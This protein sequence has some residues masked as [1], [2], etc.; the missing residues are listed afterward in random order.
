M[1][2][3]IKINFAKVNFYIKEFQKVYI[4]ENCKL[5]FYKPFHLQAKVKDNEKNLKIKKRTLIKN[6]KLKK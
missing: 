1:N 6:K 5:C 4:L 3:G 2:G